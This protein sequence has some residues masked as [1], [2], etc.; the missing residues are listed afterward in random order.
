MNLHNIYS[1][2][3]LFCFSGL[4]GKT[5]RAN[6][7]VGMFLN[8]PITIRF[9]FENAVTLK[10]PLEN[11][12][13]DAVT[14]DLLVGNNFLLAFVSA[15]VIM[16]KSP[17]EPIVLSEFDGEITTCGNIK[18]LVNSSGE[19]YLTTEKRADG[20][21]FAFSFGEKV[22]DILS[23]SELL[24]IKKQRYA[25]FEA[26]PKCPDV[27]YEKL[28]YKCLSINKENVYYPEGKIPYRWALQ[29]LIRAPHP[30]FISTKIIR[31]RR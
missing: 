28:Y 8:D 12:K 26:M 9:H 17:V 11:A 27:K 20:I 24:E 19:F 29:I 25:Y 18:K 2:G 5:S 7:F 4:D 23:Y 15:N 22:E 10:L 31:A 21:Y 30:Q 1:Y 13:F 3:Q 16:G 6:D 14:G